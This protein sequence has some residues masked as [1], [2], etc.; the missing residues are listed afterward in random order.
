MV[1]GE[2]LGAD[3]T[4]HVGFH[5]LLYAGNWL[6]H[7]H[8]REIYPSLS[9]L[10]KTN[11]NKVNLG[12]TFIIPRLLNIQNADDILVVEISQQ[13]HLSKRS[14]AEHA[15]IKRRDLLDSDL[16]AGRLMECRADRP[17]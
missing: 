9:S 15:V 14:Q 2:V 16:L 12:K 5:K 13:L 17:T 10:R 7:P 1:I 3:Y 8:F 4:M 6:N 11:L